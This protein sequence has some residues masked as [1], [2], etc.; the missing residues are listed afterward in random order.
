MF[1]TRDTS[2]DSVTLWAQPGEAVPLQWSVV[3]SVDILELL[4]M[5]VQFKLYI[6]KQVHS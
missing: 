5:G 2:S 1:C 6:A 4:K 3:A